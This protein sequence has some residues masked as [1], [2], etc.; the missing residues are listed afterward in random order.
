MHH[1]IN[2]SAV[3]HKQR[4]WICFN[5]FIIHW[6]PT[7]EVTI[8]LF[9]HLTTCCFIKFKSVR[10]IFNNLDLLCFQNFTDNIPKYAYFMEE[11]L[12]LS[13]AGW[14]WNINPNHSPSFS[15]IEKLWLYSCGVSQIFQ[16]LKHAFLGWVLQG[17]RVMSNMP[18][19]K[20]LQSTVS[21]MVEF[22]GLHHHHLQKT[23][24]YRGYLEQNRD[25]CHVSAMQ[26]CLPIWKNILLVFEPLFNKICK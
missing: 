14:P 22:F 13:A 16:L 6:R 24:Y 17:L 15:A 2:S 3:A 1:Q 21:G 11:Q 19:R 5:N 10:N 20:D 25:F 26:V 8:I 18:C 7:V 23:V 12:Y 4:P 9:G